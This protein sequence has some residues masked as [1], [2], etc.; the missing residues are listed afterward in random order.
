MKNEEFN[1]TEDRSSTEIAS[2]I[3]ERR[4]RSIYVYEAAI[5]RSA[6]S[7]LKLQAGSNFGFIFKIGNGDGVNVES[8]T[9]KAVTK[10]NSL[11][12]HPYWNPHSNCGVRWTLV[13]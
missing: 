8:G 2:D 7:D 11:S 9:D 13:N 4:N 1:D 12:L 5:P 6:P 3:R 10:T